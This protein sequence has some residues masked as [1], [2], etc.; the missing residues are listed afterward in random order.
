[1]RT[2]D[3][4]RHLLFLLILCFL[5]PEPIDAQFYN[6]HQMT[7]GKNRV[8]YN[9]FFWEYFR[10][11]RF[12]I[13][14]NE[15]GKDLAL[16]TNKVAQ[17][18]LEKTEAFFDYTLDKRLIFLVYNKLTDFR[19]SNIG[20]ISGN[21]EYNTGGVT[22]IVNNKVFLYY[23]GDHKNYDKQIR[24]SITEVMINEMLYG[25]DLKENMTNSTLI[26]LPEWYRA[27]LISY[28]SEKWSLDI[29]NKVRD[30]IINQRFKKFNRLEGEDAIIAGHSF[31]KFIAD[32]Y[33][34]NVLPNI[35]YL[36]RINKNVNSGFLYV[37]GFTV[38]E[39]S[40]QWLDYYNAKYTAL[41]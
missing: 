26:N 7:F 20:L 37:I 3:K 31:W 8:Q 12:D 40:E 13:Y 28:A 27:G 17:K 35:V 21:D 2:T 24:A 11:K 22:K 34:E 29:D 18:E 15:N 4:F 38:K 14:F 6:G 5:L 9:N 23:E 25:T 10:Y 41:K 33:G 30:A 39:L 32:T 1:L 19:Q 16:Y 36:T